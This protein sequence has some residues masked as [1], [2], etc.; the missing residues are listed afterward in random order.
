[1]RPWPSSRGAP[2]AFTCPSISMGSTRAMRQGWVHP[3]Q[4]ESPTERPT[5]RARQQRATGKVLSMDMVE[6]N[7]VLDVANRT[8]QT[9]GR[10]HPVRAWQDNSPPRV[11]IHPRL[12]LG[13]RFVL[14]AWG[15]TR[16]RPHRHPASNLGRT[17][18]ESATAP[19]SAAEHER[20]RS[21]H[22]H[23]PAGRSGPCDHGTPTR[24]LVDAPQ[25]AITEGLNGYSPQ[26]SVHPLR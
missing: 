1:M 26:V 23:L 6:L 20:A 13:H 10:S 8:G 18:Q 16:R 3:W 4:V 19:R 11:S 15:T 22:G 14:L 12:A 5:W 21:A 2:R 25:T 7:P 9:C 24:S 17:H